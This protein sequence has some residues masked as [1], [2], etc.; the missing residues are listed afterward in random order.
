MNKTF[1][2]ILGLSSNASNQDIKKAYRTLSYQ[3]HP[4]KTNNDPIKEEKYKEINEAYETLSDNIKRNQYDYEMSMNSSHDLNDILHSFMNQNKKMKPNSFSRKETPMNHIF[5]MMAD[6][7]NLPFEAPVFMHMNPEMDLQHNVQNTIEYPE[8][9]NVNINIDYKQA[10]DGCCIPIQIK[11]EIQNS[12]SLKEEHETLYIDIPCG[13]DQNEIITIDNKGNILNEKQGPI[14]IH[15][16]L[17][18]HSL[19]RRNGMDL[20]I[21]HHINFKESLCGFSFTIDHLNGDTIKLNHSKGKIILNKTSRSFHNM[22][23]IRGDKKGNLIIEFI[24][25]PPNNITEEQIKLIESI[26]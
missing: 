8:D 5:N 7:D 19:F 11:R 3:Y 21:E 23:F 24:V 1:Y 15:I 13:I 26:F 22:G 4:D 25:T 10:Y 14:K 12:N 16:Q 20:I 2:D 6:F 18:N 17:L 9:I